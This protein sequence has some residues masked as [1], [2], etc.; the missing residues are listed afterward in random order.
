MPKSSDK[1]PAVQLPA[2]LDQKEIEKM[3]QE[4]IRKMAPLAKEVLKMI[5]DSGVKV[6]AENAHDNDVY[7]A[8]AREVIQYLLDNNIKYMDKEFLFQLMLRPIEDIKEIV[9]RSLRHSFDYAI[10]KF[11]GKDLMD[12]TIGDLDEKIKK[13]EVVHTSKPVQ[14]N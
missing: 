1:K 12:V 7:T 4:R 10:D 11:F 8:V 3:A 6:D 14:G 2:G 13:V 9:I 5:A